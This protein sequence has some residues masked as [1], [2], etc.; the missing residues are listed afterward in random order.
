MQVGIEVKLPA[1]AGIDAARIIGDELTGATEAALVDVQEQ[2]VRRTP[3]NFG[4]L[5]RAWGREVFPL[6]SNAPTLGRVFNTLPYAL[7]VETG[8]RPGKW[9]PFAPIALWVKR[10]LRV[11]IKDLARVTFAVQRKIG[12]EGTT[13]AWMA[14]DGWAAALPSVRGRFRVAL[15]RINGRL[16]GGRS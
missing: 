16:R 4:Q 11:A 2:V 5:R 9:P 14:R 13:G 3:A 1:L 7:P 12:R 10:K 8:R 15:R 6:G